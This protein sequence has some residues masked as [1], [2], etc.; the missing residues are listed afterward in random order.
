MTSYNIA[1]LEG[2]GVGHEVL[3][4]AIQVLEK[5]GGLF[6]L[7]FNFHDQNWGCDRF[8]NTG[9]WIPDDGFDWLREHD[10]I[11]FG[12]VGDPNV[13]DH[14]SLWGLLIKM[15][16]ELDQ[17]VN[18]RPMRLFDGVTPK[19][20]HL[21]GAID[22]VVCREN[23][24]GEYS[25]VGGIQN[26]GTERE[27]AMQTAYFSR[28]GVDRVVDYAF[29][30]AVSH[31]RQLVTSVTKSNGIRHTMPFWDTRFLK[32]ASRYPSTETASILIDNLCAQLVM[33]P[34]DFDVMVASNLFG[35]IITDII[36]AVCGSLG[37]APSGNLNISGANPSMF[38]PVH[39]S[40]PDIAGEG[41]ANPIAQIW[42]AAMMLEHLSEKVA[43][44]AIVLAIETMLADSDGPKTPDLYGGI[45]NTK[46]VTKAILAK[47]EVQKLDE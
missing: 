31:Q 8:L 14:V 21:E 40:A 24:E 6:D 35:D 2:D 19:I 43:A 32:V 47:L 17:C 23:V 39:G 26:K 29:K 30:Y 38:E 11:L 12:A 28:I 22:I 16:R 20:R 41:I 25:D 4:P 33:R 7:Q 27:V 42:S 15:R 37:L 18:L 34:W 36:P 46:D 13:P 45:A 9:V 10:A 1:I 5:V 44:D 3:P